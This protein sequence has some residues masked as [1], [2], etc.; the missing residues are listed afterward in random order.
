MTLQHIFR[1]STVGKL[2]EIALLFLRGYQLQLAK[3]Y[4]T[5]SIHNYEV[6]FEQTLI[7]GKKFPGSFLRGHD[8]VLHPFSLR[9]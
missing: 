3:T 5:L 1:R 4:I 6:I 7:P 2:L 9:Q 8:Q